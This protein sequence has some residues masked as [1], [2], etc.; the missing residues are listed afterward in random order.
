[1]ERLRAPKPGVAGSSP[2]ASVPRPLVLVAAL[3]VLLVSPALAR[4]AC[5]APHRPP[6]VTEVDASALAAGRADNGV[7]PGAR[8]LVLRSARPRTRTPGRHRTG[9]LY[10]ARGLAMQGEGI[11]SDGRMY[12]FAGPYTLTWRNERARHAAVPERARRLDEREA[13]VD[14]AGCAIRAGDVAHAR[15]LARRRGRPAPDSTRE[16]GLRPRYCGTPAHGWFTA[17]DT[18]GAILGFHIDVFRAPPAKPWFSRVLRRQKV[19]VVPAGLP[20]PA[21]VHCS[22]AGVH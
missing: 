5:P 11:G 9:W 13:R 2:V 17:A 3:L 8:A 14:R 20:R 16:L 7:L 19:F 18:G 15:V 10:S 22:R 1:M 6:P 12:H 21:R 4:A